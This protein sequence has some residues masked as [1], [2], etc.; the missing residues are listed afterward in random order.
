MDDWISI[1]LLRHGVTKANEER[2]YLGWTDVP[3]TEAA[4]EKLRAMRLNKAQFDVCFTSDLLRA[5]DTAKLLYPNLQPIPLKAFRE[6]HFGEWEMK[7]YEELKHHSR[8]RA[9]ID[10]PDTVRPPGGEAYQEMA[11]RVEAGFQR[12]RSEINR[13]GRKE[14][15]LVSHG[16]VMRYLLSN[17]TRDKRTFFEWS[18]PHD[19]GYRLIWKRED[20]KDGVACTLF[21]EVPLMAK[22]SG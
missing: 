22:G 1:T 9:W 4:K 17:Y 3:L 14:I 18:T 21:Q 20:W 15:L 2:R 16:G 11:R 5:T 7:T 13:S 19:L 8:Y 10:A 6:M 12:I